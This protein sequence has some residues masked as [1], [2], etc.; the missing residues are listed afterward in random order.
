M[1]EIFN[2]NHKYIGFFDDKKCFNKKG[3]LISHLEDSKVKD[4][5]GH[6][7]LRMDK[8][9]DIFFGN[10]QVGF[11]LDSKI[12]YREYPT[13]V[14]SKERGEILN[15]EGKV[16]LVLKGDLKKIGDLE[17]FGI[18]TTFLESFWWKKVVVLAST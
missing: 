8:Y 6:I 14:I 5:K 17:Y 2:K 3:N 1:I 10:D 15:P 18:T 11:I 13:F 16:L 4:K 12:Y 7:L 9:N